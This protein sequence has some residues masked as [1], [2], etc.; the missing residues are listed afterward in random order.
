MAH[1]IPSATQHDPSKCGGAVKQVPEE[2]PC[3]NAKWFD[4]GV[5][6]RMRQIKTI[7]DRKVKCLYNDIGG[8]RTMQATPRNERYETNGPRRTRRREGP[9]LSL[10]PAKGPPHLLKLWSKA[11]VKNA[12]CG[13]CT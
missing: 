3:S 13:K 2:I 9:S 12:D 5:W 7:R 11:S 1:F 8:L 10:V 4:P 6:P